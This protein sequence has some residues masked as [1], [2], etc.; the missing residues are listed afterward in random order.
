M[1]ST[2]KGFGRGNAQLALCLHGVTP[3]VKCVKRGRFPWLISF[4][5]FHDRKTLLFHEV[6]VWF[7][8]QDLG[9]CRAT[10]SDA[11]EA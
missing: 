2:L 3:W 7:H 5:C 1:P 11:S 8:S 9:L 10:C 4:A 6:V